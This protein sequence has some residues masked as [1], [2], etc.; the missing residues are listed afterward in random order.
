MDRLTEMTCFVRAV[1]SGSFATAGRALAMSSQLVG[2]RVAAL[3]ARLGVQLLVR[4]TRRHR[5][6]EAGQSFYDRCRAV[7]HEAEE[8]E[9]AVA[10]F[11][12][13]ARG[14]LVISAPATFGSA[15]LMPFI[16]DYLARNEAV[17][18]KLVLTDR[19][20][21]LVAERFDAV[22]RLGALESSSLIARRLTAVRLVAA[23]S[24]GYLRRRGRPSTPSDLRDHE[25]LLYDYWSR[26]PLADWTFERN[27]TTETVTVSGRLQANDGRGL[28][29]CAIAG[30]GIVLQDAEIVGRH[31][32]VGELEPVLP[33]YAGPLREMHVVYP[34][35]RQIAPKLRSFVDAMAD[36]FGA[37]SHS[38]RGVS[39][40]ER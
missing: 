8:A 35:G 27:G 40:A 23:A 39:T 13:A 7:I 20:V 5:V 2:K 33:A 1:E 14:Q 9:T 29:A 16:A 10:E 36:S 28:I 25:C 26:P 17:S 18:V 4:T 32:A 12:G 34:P 3:E 15:R 24:P 19:P 22:V 37:G 21:D 11:G 31:F 6:T 38:N 30:H